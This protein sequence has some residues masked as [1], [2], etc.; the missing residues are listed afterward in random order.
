ML[1]SGQEVFGGGVR[2]TGGLGVRGFLR[3]SARHQ[4]KLSM[5][6]VFLASM[7]TTYV[8]VPSHGPPAIRVPAASGHPAFAA[9]NFYGKGP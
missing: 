7:L 9:R 3:L 1:V 4:H 8:E 5:L 6:I 2:P